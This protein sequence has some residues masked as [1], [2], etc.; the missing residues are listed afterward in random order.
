[1]SW[2][3]DWLAGWFVCKRLKDVDIFIYIYLKTTST[4]II[5]IVLQT[6]KLDIILWVGSR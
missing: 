1:M 6:H 5:Y 4:Q 2:L 3:V